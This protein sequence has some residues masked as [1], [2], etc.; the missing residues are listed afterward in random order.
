MYILI[1]LLLIS[2]NLV[3]SQEIDISP[4]EYPKKEEPSLE[5]NSFIHGDFHYAN[6]LWRKEQISGILDYEYSG[7]GLKEQDIAWTLVLRP[8]QKFMDNIEDIKSFLA[9]YN[10]L[11][12]YTIKN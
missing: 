5:F 3:L 10:Q 12:T 9:G 2:S 8:S 1:I 4:Y 11:G 7:Y 6:I